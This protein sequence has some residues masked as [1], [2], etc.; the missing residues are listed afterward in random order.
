MWIF[1]LY[2]V[3]CMYSV[4]MYNI[5]DIWDNE[6]LFEFLFIVFHYKIRT[7]DAKVP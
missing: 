2:F 6:E 4:Y 7:E 3:S 5:S 1:F